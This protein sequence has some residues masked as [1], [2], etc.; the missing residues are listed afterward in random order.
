MANEIYRD[1]G[2]SYRT[3]DGI[4]V[5]DDVCRGYLFHR[6]GNLRFDFMWTLHKQLVLRKEPTMAGLVDVRAFATSVAQSCKGMTQEEK[7]EIGKMD[8]RG[9]KK[10][11]VPGEYEC[12]LS[13]LVEDIGKTSG[14]AYWYF[15]LKADN[16]AED[17]MMFNLL[18]REEK[19][20]AN[21]LFGFFSR[22]GKVIKLAVIRRSEPMF[23]SLLKSLEVK[24]I[25]KVSYWGEHL[26]Y[27]EKGDWRIVDRDE[28]E[29]VCPGAGEPRQFTDRETALV[30]WSKPVAEGGYGKKGKPYEPKLEL[31]GLAPNAALE[32]SV[33]SAIEAT[34]RISMLIDEGKDP[35]ECIAEVLEGLVQP[36]KPT[37]QPEKKKVTAPPWGPK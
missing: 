11:N 35:D 14:K 32:E 26:K 24:V 33:Q 17:R 15:P 23:I 12:L 5:S 6:V 18:D 10:L 13:P 28:K 2:D 20:D 34:V 22:L 21:A 3:C 25:I 27:V 1:R 19:F 8:N 37:S 9:Q 7:A 30:E 16:G 4:R 31:V 36:E 29:V